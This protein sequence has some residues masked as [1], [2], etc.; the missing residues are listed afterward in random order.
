MSTMASTQPDMLNS[1]LACTNARRSYYNLQK[2]STLSNEQLEEVLSDI[3]IS[4]PTP[5]NAQSNRV[6]VLL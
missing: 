6:V 1:S 3:M 5:F 2:A 4:T